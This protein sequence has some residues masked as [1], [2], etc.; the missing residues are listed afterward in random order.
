MIKDL[1]Q[2][3]NFAKLFSVVYSLKD[4]QGFYNR[5]YDEVDVVMYLEN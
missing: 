4:F 1:K 5:L 3:K 2:Y